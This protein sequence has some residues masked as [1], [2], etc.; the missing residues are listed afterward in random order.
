MSTFQ[1]HTIESAPAGS[2]Q[3]LE[4]AQKGLGFVPNLYGVL[5]ES[6]ALLEAYTSIG[7]TFDRS[8]FDAT[9]RQVVLLS[10]SLE[11]G[12]D[13]CMAAHSTIAGMQGV[14]EHVVEALRAGTPLAD[15]RLETLGQFT[16]QVVRERGRVSEQDVQAFLDAGFTRAQVFEVILGVGMKTLSNYANHIAHTPLDEAFEAQAWTASAAG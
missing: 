6:P 5:A 1:V 7:S 12:C 4:K 11:N 15:A 3:I 9:E 14:P 10:V 16:R 8:S 2:T 13:Y